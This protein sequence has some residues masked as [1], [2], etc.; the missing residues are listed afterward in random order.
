MSWEVAL[1]IISTG[2]SYTQQKK[3]KKKAEQARKAQMKEANSVLLSTTDSDMEL[4]VLYGTRKV[5]GTRVHQ[6]AFSSLIIPSNTDAGMENFWTT[7]YFQEPHTPHNIY[8]AS[9]MTIAHEI[10]KAKQGDN[11]HLLIQ[12]SFGFGPISKVYR[13]MLGGRYSDFLSPGKTH[14]ICHNGHFGSGSI[15]DAPYAPDPL[16]SGIAKNL[17]NQN[18]KIDFNVGR[19]LS[20]YKAFAVRNFLI[21][22]VLSYRAE[23]DSI[24]SGSTPGEVIYSKVTLDDSSQWSNDF[25]DLT[26]YDSLSSIPESFESIFWMRIPHTDTTGADNRIAHLFVHFDPTGNSWMRDS[27]TLSLEETLEG[28][29]HATGGRTSGLYNLEDKFPALFNGGVSSDLIISPD[30]GSGWHPL[31]K[32]TLEVKTIRG[33]VV[34]AN[35][36]SI[37]DGSSNVNRVNDISTT[38]PYPSI[39][40]G[41]GNTLGVMSYFSTTIIDDPHAESSVVDRS[42]AYFVKQHYTSFVL[43]NDP[44]DEDASQIW[45]GSVPPVQSICDGRKVWSPHYNSGSPITKHFEEHGNPQGHNPALI[46]LDYLLLED[47]GVGL[48][49]GLSEMSDSQQAAAIEKVIDIDSFKVASQQC[50]INLDSNSSPNKFYQ[51]ELYPGAAKETDSETVDDQTWCYFNGGEWLSNRCVIPNT[52]TLKP[53]TP[54]SRVVKSF[55]CDLPINTGASLTENIKDIL[56]TMN[57]YLTYSQGK[58]GLFLDYLKIWQVGPDVIGTSSDEFDDLILRMPNEDVLESTGVQYNDAGHTSDGHVFIA[59]SNLSF[60][61]TP[62]TY[63]DLDLFNTDDWQ[64]I[65][66][67]TE[68]IILDKSIKYSPPSV[69]ERFNQFKIRFPDVSKNWEENEAVWPETAE[70]FSENNVIVWE[71]LLSYSEDDYVFYGDVVY[72]ALTNHSG[73]TSFPSVDTTNWKT[74]HHATFIYED[75]FVELVSDEFISGITNIYNARAL[76][77]QRCRMSRTSAGLSMTLNAEGWLFSEGDVI[78]VTISHLGFTNTL[79]RVMKMVYK[80]DT[81]IDIELSYYTNNN[82][83]WT[84]RVDEIPKLLH[85]N[86]NLMLSNIE[87]FSS[88]FINEDKDLEISWSPSND[89]RVDSFIVYMK[90]NNVPDWKLNFDSARTSTTYVN[91]SVR[92]PVPLIYRTGDI[93]KYTDGLHYQCI[94]DHSTNTTTAVPNYGGSIYWENT[95]IPLTN[96]LTEVGRTNRNSFIIRDINK[97]P[98]VSHT[99]AIQP[100]GNGISPGFYGNNGMTENTVE[101]TKTFPILDSLDITLERKIPGTEI[102][103]ARLLTKY[104]FDPIS[105]SKPDGL[106]VTLEPRANY[107]STDVDNKVTIG[108]DLGDTLVVAD[109]GFQILSSSWNDDWTLNNDLVFTVDSW[110]NNE[111]SITITE[112]MSGW[113]INDTTNNGLYLWFIRNLGDIYVSTKTYNFNDIVT[114]GHNTY[115]SRISS[116]TNNDPETR[117]SVWELITSTDPRVTLPIRVVRFEQSTRKIF[118]ARE[119]YMDLY[120]NFTPTTDDRLLWVFSAFVDERTENKFLINNGNIPEIISYKYLGFGENGSIKFFGVENHRSLLKGSTIPGETS[121]QDLFVLP[122]GDNINY[123]TEKFTLPPS[124]F[125]TNNQVVIGRDIDLRGLGSCLGTTCFYEENQDGSVT[126]GNILDL[127]SSSVTINVIP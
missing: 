85:F 40:D 3:A 126:Y 97:N 110:D 44:T 21:K 34:L 48:I 51:C 64:E 114:H 98:G 13:Y 99:F 124:I 121:N 89:G 94:L 50:S 88:N 30:D 60:T 90:E 4:P 81:T 112:G 95:P 5:G 54:F 36:A 101:Y 76:A 47:F 69:S 93:V 111:S 57:G 84:N 122:V 87:G 113:T 27:F 61:T 106:L 67:I 17:T 49:D 11:K 58:F 92:N 19:V 1:F 115:K 77:E 25:T 118:L 15:Q 116:N 9:D 8:A 96:T 37:L 7:N 117:T 125:N 83:L 63:L 12:A 43:Y 71:P 75:N 105:H 107:N 56:S 91:L 72:K 10:P 18:L 32:Y 108:S 20:G 59:K 78:P 26:T 14:V 86:Y 23:L 109:D 74:D 79:F 103:V 104:T 41:E 80:L 65:V 16:V 2:Y 123:R 31:T 73:E 53:A 45:G 46:L 22:D 29:S 38:I 119:P 35:S 33:R 39:H 62:V 24:L 6:D 102:Y 42:K 120:E 70:S 55:E 127:S 82:Y 68:S 66:G 52:S 28:I 100:K